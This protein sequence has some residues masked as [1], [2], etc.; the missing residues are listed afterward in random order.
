MPFNGNPETSAKRHHQNIVDNPQ[1]AV[2]FFSKRFEIFFKDVLMKQW[3][4]EDW[5][6][7]FEWQHRGSSHVHGIGKRKDAPAID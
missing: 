1:I 6:Y 5:W 2:W 4:L 3:D 7:R